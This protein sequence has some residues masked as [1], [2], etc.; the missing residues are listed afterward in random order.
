MPSTLGW[1]RSLAWIDVDGRNE[2]ILL[3]VPSDFPVVVVHEH[4]VMAAEQH[5][6][7][8]VS[9]PFV[10]SPVLAMMC[11]TPGRRALAFGKDATAV[12]RGERYALPIREQSFASTYVQ[13]LAPVEEHRHVTG[14][15]SKSLRS[16]KRH[17]YGLSL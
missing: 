11:F 3:A 16:G 13:R 15:T 2:P 17:R 12:A 9:A 14:T 8:C 4:V 7:S 10:A 6:E 5:P 1:N